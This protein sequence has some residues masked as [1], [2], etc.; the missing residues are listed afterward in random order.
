MTTTNP[1]SMTNITES[2]EST[3]KISIAVTPEEKG[4]FTIFVTKLM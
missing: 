4:K 2:P 3:I 1:N